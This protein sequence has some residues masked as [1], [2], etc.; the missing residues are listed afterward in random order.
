MNDNCYQCQHH[1][2]IPGDAHIRCVNPDPGMTGNARGIARGW[3][4]YPINF[5]PVWKTK[6]CV[7]YS[8]KKV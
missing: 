2:D 8:E 5:D 1:R 7:N 4:I 3:F 6:T